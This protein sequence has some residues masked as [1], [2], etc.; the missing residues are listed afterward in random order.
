MRSEARPWRL[1][2]SGSLPGAMN[3]ALD[4]ALL[5]AVA[6]GDSPPVL[7]LYH[8]QPAALSL[9]YAQKVSD[10]VDLSACRRAGLDVVRRARTAAPNAI[11]PLPG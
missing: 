9:G 8:W 4:D 3:M 11:T 10:G 1:I 6:D 7:R 2:R 5:Q